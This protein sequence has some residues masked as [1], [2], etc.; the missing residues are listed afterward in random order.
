[1]SDIAS[2]DIVISDIF[3]EHQL[4][5]SLNIYI[6]IT[7]DTCISNN[8]MAPAYILITM[9]TCIGFFSEPFWYSSLE[10]AIVSRQRHFLRQ[11]Y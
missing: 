4:Y 5:A 11:T 7:M 3:R 6:L 9:V 1:M 8:I 2:V 10:I